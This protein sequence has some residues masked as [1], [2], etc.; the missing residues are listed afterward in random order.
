M[1][2]CVCVARVIHLKLYITGVTALHLAA[3]R[4]WL[5]C[6][7]VLVKAGAN[8]NAQDTAMRTPLHHAI[9]SHSTPV[10]MYS[11][12]LQ[13]YIYCVVHCLWHL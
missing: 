3:R 5:L 6:A 10:C 13:T 2:V 1:Y 4:G 12:I 9:V 7:R 11:T 8:L